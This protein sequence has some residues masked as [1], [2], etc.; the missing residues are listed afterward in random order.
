MPRSRDD[1]T[2]TGPLGWRKGQWES[3]ETNPIEVSSSYIPNSFMHVLGS[4][5]YDGKF[6]QVLTAKL[7]HRDKFTFS[8]SFLLRSFS[9][10]LWSSCREVRPS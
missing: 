10:P 5:F 2:Y 4:I 8:C 6:L 3:L 1:S 7:K 9:T